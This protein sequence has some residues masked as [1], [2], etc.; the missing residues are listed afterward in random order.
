MTFSLTMFGALLLLFYGLKLSAFFSGSETGFYR[1]STLQLTLEKQRGDR[2]ASR[3]FYFVT[4]PERFV[5][6]TLVGNNVANYLTTLAIGLIVGAFWQRASGSA[7]VIVTLLLTPVIFIFGELIPKSLYYRAPMQ[8]LRGGAVG[9]RFCYYLFLPISYPL[10]LVSRFVSRFGNAE[11]RPLEVVFGRN[12]LYGVLE[13]GEREGLLTDL[14][15]TL[16]EN[17]MQV[18]DQPVGDV[19]IPSTAVDGVS[20]HSSI[21]DVLEASERMD[22]GI[23][24]LH[25]EGQPTEWTASLRVADMLSSELAPRLVMEPLQEFDVF[26][27]RLEVL[28]RLFQNYAT[29]GAVTDGGR[30]VGIILRRTLVSQL[31]RVIR[32]ASTQ[33]ETVLAGTATSG[34]GTP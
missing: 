31:F 9:F 10:I 28:T 11:K 17:L 8:L 18:A 2:V 29:I 16:A 26:T 24:L 12:R 5:T 19:M 32:P 14:Q 1:V 34:D 21:E 25:R 7:E 22:S 3:L 4:H 13:A 20:E 6:T 27:P 23:V 33:L 15:R 30:V